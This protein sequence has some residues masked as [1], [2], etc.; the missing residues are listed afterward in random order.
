VIRPARLSDVS[1]I[2]AVHVSAWEG[3]V[4]TPSYERRLELWN[5]V[6]GGGPRRNQ[7]W[8]ALD[9][10]GKIVGFTSAGAARVLKARFDG[11]L[12]AI[13]V[14]PA[15]QRQGVGR[16]L[17]RQ[18]FEWFELKRFGS[19]MVW[20]PEDSGA[21]A[22][23]ARLGAELLRDRREAGSGPRLTKEAAMAWRKSPGCPAWPLA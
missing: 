17:A 15:S 7:V 6:L 11:E 4:E 12:T 22:F 21:Q 3:S 20:V 10:I 13:Y 18:V 16:A 9:G 1:G 8:V 5:H 2:A 23:M 14:A 19:A